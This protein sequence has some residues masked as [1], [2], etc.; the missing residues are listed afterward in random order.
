[1]AKRFFSNHGTKVKKVYEPFFTES[2]ARVLVCVGEE[3]LH[4][5]IQSFKEQV[6]IQAILKRFELG[7]PSGLNAQVGMYGD[8]TRCPENLAQFLNLQNKAGQLFAVLPADVRAAFNNDVNQFFVSYG[9][10]AWLEK[11]KPFM[12]E[13]NPSGGVSNES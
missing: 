6:D 3:D 1:M 12:R 5:Y 7:D 8:F 4:G 13:D 9:S 10:D 2:G 11:V